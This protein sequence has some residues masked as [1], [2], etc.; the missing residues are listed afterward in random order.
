MEKK[1]IRSFVY[2]IVVSAYMIISY[3]IIQEFAKTPID[4]TLIGIKALAGFGSLG[5]GLVV[6]L[7]LI[8]KKS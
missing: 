8:S 6:F 3:D 1:E 4:F 5:I 7:F 2:G